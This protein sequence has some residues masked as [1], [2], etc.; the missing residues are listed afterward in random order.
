MSSDI[1]SSILYQRIKSFISSGNGGICRLFIWITLSNK[2][3]NEITDE[4]NST[5]L[6]ISENFIIIIC[7]HGQYVDAETFVCLSRFCN[8]MLITAPWRG[9]KYCSF[10][11]VFYE[12]IGIQTHILTITINTNPFQLKSSH[13]NDFSCKHSSANCC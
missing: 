11:F 8:L 6:N 4:S 7:S 5:T 3:D 12:M 9:V 10:L 2:K 1:F 13:Q